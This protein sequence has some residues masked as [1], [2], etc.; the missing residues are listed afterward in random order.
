MMKHTI[1]NN[2]GDTDF[3]L[4]DDSGSWQKCKTTNSISMFLRKTYRMIDTCDSRIAS[5]TTDGEMFVVKNPISFETTIIPQYFD[6]KKLSS[7]SRQLN[8]YGFK[9]MQLKPVHKSEYNTK[10]SKYLTF[11]HENFKRGRCDLL[12]EIRRSTRTSLPAGHSDN[13]TNEHNCDAL[14]K[15]VEELEEKIDET[16]RDFNYGLKRIE[17]ECM[18]RLE[19][20]FRVMQQPQQQHMSSSHQSRFMSTGSALENPTSDT[21]KL[22]FHESFANTNNGT[23]VPVRPIV[24]EE[25]SIWS[26]T[27][28]SVPTRQA[29]SSSHQEMSFSST[30]YNGGCPSA[31]QMNMNSQTFAGT[32][33]EPHPNQKVLPP[34]QIPMHLSRKDESM[35]SNVSWGDRFLGDLLTRLENSDTDKPSFVHQRRRSTM[36]LI[37]ASVELPA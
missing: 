32:T 8:F 22:C 18:S 16:R 37:L 19:R 9:K 27:P 2:E 6:H 3:I 1:S 11:Y 34:Q 33:L 35:A 10:T 26:P 31:I 5:W 25:C 21:S 12:K 30:Y 17:V 14:Q 13:L 28:V 20:M 24:S 29:T 36:D 23:P 7:F 4:P 15:R